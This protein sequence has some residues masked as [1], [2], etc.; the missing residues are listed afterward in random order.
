MMMMAVPMMTVI[1]IATNPEDAIDGPHRAA[2]TGA[3]RAANDGAHRACRAAT[4]VRALLR[5]A[6][7]A[8]DDTLRMAGMG[9]REQRENKR[10]GC[11]R[12]LDAQA[13]GRRRCD[14]LRRVHSVHLHQFLRR[15]RYGSREAG[16]GNADPPKRLRCHGKSKRRESAESESREND[17]DARLS[18]ASAMFA[19]TM[20]SAGH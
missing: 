4:L 14:R 19:L 11:K 17:A 15:G 5:A 1:P 16:T 12:E 2:D 9:N 6:L 3:D 13:G 20:R 7:H 8:A 10:C 18:P